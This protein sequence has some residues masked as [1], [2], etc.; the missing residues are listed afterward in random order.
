MFCE[1]KNHN[2]GLNRKI[3]VCENGDIKN[4]PTHTT[5]FGNVNT[6][7]LSSILKN[8]EFTEVWDICNDRIE[9][10]KFCKYRYCCVSNTEVVVFKGLF[11]KKEYCDKK[12]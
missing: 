11:Y 1:A 6:T 12:F 4:Y 7:K 5:V 10:C 2:L 8:K 9:K 3:C